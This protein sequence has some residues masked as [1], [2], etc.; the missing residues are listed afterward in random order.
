MPISRHVLDRYLDTYYGVDARGVVK[1][2]L[3]N[4]DG[5]DLLPEPPARR[6]RVLLHRSL[7]ISSACATSATCKTAVAMS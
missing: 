1:S 3:L 2:I 7:Q 5:Q 6:T 4:V